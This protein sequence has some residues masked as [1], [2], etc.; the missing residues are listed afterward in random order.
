MSSKIVRLKPYQYVHVHDNNSN[1]TRVLVGP[2]SYTC[3]DHEAVV[4]GEPVSC[5]AV[6]PS[7]YCVV[8]NPVARDKKT[9]EVLLE[10]SGQVKVRTGDVEI[11]FSQEPFA[12]YPGEEIQQ[13]VTRMEVLSAL[14]A[15]RLYATRDFDDNGVARKAGDEW[16]V[17]G[18]CT[19]V[20]RIEAEVRSKVDATVIDHS[21]A[22][23]LQAVCDFTDRNDIPRLTG[24][25]W[26]HEE[27]GAY[28]PQV[29]ERIVEVVKAQV[30]TEKR[31]IH[32]LAVNNFIDRFGKE[33]Q[34]GEQWLVTVRDCPHFIPSPNEVVATPVNLVTVG[35]HQYCVVIDYVDEDGVQHF[36]RK[37]LRN[38]TTTFFLHPGE[39]LEG[40]KVKDVFI[41]ADNEA[42]VLFADEDLVD[43]D[44]K[45]RAAGDR[46]MIRGPRSYTPPVEVNVVDKRRSIPLDLNEGVYIRDLQTGTVRAHIGSTVMLNEH[47]ALWDKPLSPLV[48]ELLSN[49]RLTKNMAARDTTSGK[50]ARRKP[51]QVV[52]CNVPHNAVVQVYDYKEKRA[53]VVVGPELVALQPDEEFTVVSLSAGKPK[54]EG[55]IKTLALHLGPDFMTDVLLVETKD[56]AR[57]Q[58][59]LSFNWEFDASAADI[60]DRIFNVPDFVGDACK[61]ISSRVRGSVAAES[62]DQFHR[63]STSIIRRAVFG[64]AEDFEPL[65]FPNN[66]L[67]ITSVDIQGVDPVDPKTREALQKSV[68]LAI[69]ITTKSQEATA[70]HLATSKEQSAHGRLERQVIQDKA[71]AEEIRKQLLDIQAGNAAIESTGSSTAQAKAT[72]EAKRIEGENECEVARLRA[73]AETVMMRAEIDVLKLQHANEIDYV[74]QMHTLDIERE[75]EL[76]RVEADKFKR[77][78]QAIG[79]DTIIALARAGPKVQARLLGALGLQGYLVTDGTNPINLFNTAKGLANQGQQAAA[80]AA[81]I[82]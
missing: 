20:P 55:L 50:K 45:R 36:G 59:Q 31:A 48:E 46:W 17:R 27:P 57:L 35:A 12:L 80:A 30:L 82:A 4:Q 61:A 66:G 6:P 18:P 73:E 13:S 34:A 23:R 76:A 19:Y 56:H 69:E 8:L 53:R 52:T 3:Q 44:G 74:D 72:A 14:Q 37:Q 29:E 49:P 51:W 63:N 9:N 47:E 2:Q 7:H 68:Q 42:V 64:K 75:R 54:Q 62:F 38:G 60:K 41:L 33:R 22:L 79:R 71:K 24:E 65:V 77:T 32:V 78:V 11:R 21:T 25:Q 43:S 26:L 28:I 16:L 70:R 10:K 81:S 58:L 40:G 15:V 5:I 67:I 39:S 1:V